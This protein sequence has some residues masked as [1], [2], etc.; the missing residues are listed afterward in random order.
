SNKKSY[1]HLIVHFKDEW[2]YTYFNKLSVVMDERAVVVWGERKPICLIEELKASTSHITI[3]TACMF[4]FVGRY[5]VPERNGGR[6][7]ADLAEQAYVM[8]R[9]IAGDGNFFVELMPHEM[10]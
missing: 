10:T 9:E 1:A 8:L 2:A 3:G 5:L 4:G 6:V 7:R